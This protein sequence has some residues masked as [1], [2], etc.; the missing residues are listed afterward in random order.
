MQIK[1]IGMFL[2]LIGLVANA[3]AITDLQTEIKQKYEIRIVKPYGDLGDP[4]YVDDD[5]FK[6][7]LK[8]FLAEAEKQGLN[9]G[10]RKRFFPVEIELIIYLENWNFFDSQV[11][12][13][14]ADI[15]FEDN[16]IK[17]GH[18]SALAA[19]SFIIDH[20]PLEGTEEAIR[21]EL[22]NQAVRQ[23]ILDKM[24]Y[25][26]EQGVE[27]ES[28]IFLVG[29]CDLDRYNELDIAYSTQ[30]QLLQGLINLEESIANG[31]ESRSKV[32]IAP[33]VGFLVRLMWDGYYS[34]NR[35]IVD[36]EGKT[37]ELIAEY[38]ARL[39]ADRDST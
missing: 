3:Q 37:E 7:F 2:L 5:D 14:C 20:F 32:S 4:H 33:V 9:E 16:S 1:F 36:D 15:A 21:L 10:D 8:A 39:Q 35:W 22:R 28:C 24:Q 38:M 26:E 19:V 18:R 27:I 23:A 29:K 34:Y 31:D 11:C 6:S 13:T 12:Y 30:E 17:V 25:I